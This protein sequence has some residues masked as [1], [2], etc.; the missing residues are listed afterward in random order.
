LTNIWECDTFYLSRA[1]GKLFD[2]MQ[3]VWY[4]GCVGETPRQ[5]SNKM[6]D[7]ETYEDFGVTSWISGLA[8][9]YDVGGYNED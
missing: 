6:D 8:D 4:L 3:K 5:R 7:F 1:Q 9:R 2:K